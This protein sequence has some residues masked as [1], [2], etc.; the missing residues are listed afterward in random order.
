MAEAE[1][2]AGDELVVAAWHVHPAEP[3][4]VEAFDHQ[5]EFPAG[6][7]LRL[8]VHLRCIGPQVEHLVR[9]VRQ[10]NRISVQ[11]PGHDLQFSQERGPV[12][13]LALGSLQR[14]ESV[15]DHRH[16]QQLAPR[17]E[18][19][20]DL[21]LQH[22]PGLDHL[23]AGVLVLVPLLGLP[24]RGPGLPCQDLGV[25]TWGHVFPIKA[26]GFRIVLPVALRHSTNAAAA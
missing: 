23:L 20:R 12:R 25:E 11:G 15:R 13:E 14:L 21:V 1:A 4:P 6:R 2:E 8:A 3:L 16:C 17:R 24:P 7:G 5:V 10:H 26:P 18:L 19:S 9:S 22:F